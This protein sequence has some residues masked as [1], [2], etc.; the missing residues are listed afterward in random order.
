MLEC[1]EFR[2]DEMKLIRSFC[3]MDNKFRLSSL[4]MYGYKFII[5]FVCDYT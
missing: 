3:H 4:F 2:G 1:K 5:S